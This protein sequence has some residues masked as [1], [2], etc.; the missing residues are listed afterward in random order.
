MPEKFEPSMLGPSPSTPPEPLEAHTGPSVSE[1]SPEAGIDSEQTSEESHVDKDIT[2]FEM[3]ATAFRKA[4]DDIR[5]WGALPNA[6]PTAL[7]WCGLAL[8]Y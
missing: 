8:H 4:L 6:T 7:Q 3:R 1:R 2:S 5:S